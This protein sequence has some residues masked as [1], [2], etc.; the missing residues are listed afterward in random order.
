MSHFTGIEKLQQAIWC[1]IFVVREGYIL[2][3]KTWSQKSPEFRVKQLQEEDEVHSDI[4]RLH[5]GQNREGC[6]SPEVTK[7]DETRQP[8]EIPN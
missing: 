2:Y 3:L 6:N 5:P 4:Q 7:K 8:L 1:E